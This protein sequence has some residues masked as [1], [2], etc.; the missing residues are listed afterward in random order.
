MQNKETRLQF[1]P[2]TKAEWIKDPTISSETINYMEENRCSTMDFGHGEHFNE[3]D[4]KGKG[5]KSK[6]KNK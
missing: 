4:P 5:S 3:F 2:C 6:G 1:V